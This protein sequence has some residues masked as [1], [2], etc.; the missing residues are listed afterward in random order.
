V[1]ATVESVRRASWLAPAAVAAAGVA[2]LAYVGLR[3][4]ATERGFL[5]CAFHRVTGLWCPGCGMT[6][7]LHHLVNGDV[8]AALG[9]NVFLPLLVVLAGYAWLSWAVGD[10]WPLPRVRRLTNRWWVVLGVVAVA[11]GVARNLP[12]EPL[13]ALAP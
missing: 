10:R 4:P 1:T 2:G 8:V 11:Y 6:R 7:G 5:P 13:T 3:D 12:V 9:S